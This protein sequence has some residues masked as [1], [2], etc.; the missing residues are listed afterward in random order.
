MRKSPNNPRQSGMDFSLQSHRLKRFDFE[1]EVR[2]ARKGRIE[3]D[4]LSTRT[5][6]WG[7]VRHA[8]EVLV[9]INSRGPEGHGQNIFSFTHLLSAASYMSRNGK[10]EVED[11]DGTVL[12]G[13]AALNSRLELWKCFSDM[14]SFE[15]NGRKKQEATRIILSMPKGTDRTKFKDAVREW[16]QEN[17]TG[18]DFLLAFHDDTQSPHAHILV[19]TQPQI[20]FEQSYPRFRVD[21]AGIQLMRESLARLLLERGVAANATRRMTRGV[22]RPRL[23]LQ[24]WHV[25]RPHGESK[26]KKRVW[27]NWQVKSDEIMTEVLAALR[28]GERP[29]PN[30]FLMKSRKTRKAAMGYAFAF[31][32]ELQATGKPDDRQL[33][34]ELACYYRNL[35]PVRS[36]AEEIWEKK[37][38]PDRGIARSPEHED[39]FIRMG[40]SRYR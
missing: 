1:I 27:K 13:K 33:A 15:G 11:N 32:R 26:A 22:T 8:P 4:G 29:E 30:P 7:I 9:R 21:K 19:R 18:Y 2:N 23:S 24:A 10:L 12:Q 36:M 31:I 25:R 20:G 6:A 3:P 5:K 14:P 40:N 34:R 28:R 38:D 16:T 39:D 37:F 17:L 35:P